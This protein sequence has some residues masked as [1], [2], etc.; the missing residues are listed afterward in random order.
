MN[1]RMSKTVGKYRV[2]VRDLLLAATAT[3]ALAAANAQSPTSGS[4]MT[5]GD[6]VKL[7]KAGFGDDVVG[8][9]IDQAAAI[10]FKLEVSD[11][12]QLKAAGVSQNTIAAML[13]RASR[14]TSPVAGYPGAGAYP[15]AQGAGGY[16][17]PTQNGMV[18][19]S[20][21]DNGTVVLHSMAGTLSSTFAYVTSLMYANFIGLK[22]DVRIHDPLPTLIVRYPENPKGRFYLVLAEADGRNN[23]RS[24]KLGNNGLF[25]H[26]NLGAPDSDNQIEYDASQGTDGLWRLVPK[27]ALKSGE[28]GLW[29]SSQQ[30]YDFGVDL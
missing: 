6:V 23:V 11:L 20:T 19:L 25:S 24:V 1:E 16:V 7:V 27:K 2:R 12:E 8:A 17:P 22:A 10:N 14:P 21:N 4:A 28:Y 30:F 13:R 5:N 29:L 15:G 3:L 18:S 26:K 9:K